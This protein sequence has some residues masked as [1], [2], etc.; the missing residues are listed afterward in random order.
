MKALGCMVFTG[1]AT[2]GILNNGIEVEKVLEISDDIVK[3]N[4]KHFIHNYPHVPIIVPS[5][6]E[7]EDY[8]KR[9][10]N[11]N[12]DIM[13]GNPPCS[14]LSALNRN[15]R[16]DGPNNVHFFRYF[17][18]VDKIEPKTFIIEN[19]PTLLKLGKP[20]LNKM[21]DLLGDRYTFTLIRDFAMN[22]DV[23][24]KRQRTFIIGWRRDVFED[25]IPI[26]EVHKSHKV[27]KDTIGDLY[28]EEIGISKINNFELVPERS[29]TDVEFLIPKIPTNRSINYEI[30]LN[31]EKYENLLPEKYK[32]S[33]QNMLYKV[34]NGKRFWD[35]SPARVAEDKLFPSM[36]SVVELIHP[37]HNRQLTIREYARIM[38]YPDSFEFVE[39]ET[40][41]I[42]CISQGV[43]VKYFEWISG[44]VKRCLED[45]NSNA[46]NGTDVVYQHHQ[47]M[48][49][50]GFDRKEFKNTEDITVLNKE[51]RYKLEV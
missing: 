25:T 29:C 50:Q 22:H 47:S 38:G 21:V 20:I 6:W 15:A 7:N 9:L 33:I 1:S 42:Q 34:K 40:P 49:A 30:C 39:C 14:S 10:K 28:N 44:E 19:A 35:K 36:A 27:V 2:I 24:M 16:V 8:L 45:K 3:Q 11:E 18:V 17:N 13:Y 46:I 26:I 4:A 48:F 31:Y 32:K 12:Y 41:I 23:A 37:V 51:K 43:P 5:T